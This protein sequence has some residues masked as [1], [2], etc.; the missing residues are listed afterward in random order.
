MEVSGENTVKFLDE[1]QFIVRLNVGVNR[2]EVAGPLADDHAD[3]VHHVGVESVGILLAN[4]LVDGTVH[5]V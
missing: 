1:W 4:A 5:L 3:V 2:R